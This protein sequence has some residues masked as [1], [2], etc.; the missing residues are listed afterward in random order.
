[1]SATKFGLTLS[2]E[3][4]GPQRLVELASLAEAA[5]FDFVSISDHF[6]PWIPE[7]GHSPNVWP[8]LGAIAATTEQLEIAVGVTCPIMRIHPAI[9]A[10]L[11]ATTAG[12]CDGR[13][14]WGV[15]SGEALNEH[16]LGD[17][18]PPAPQRIEMLREA[19]HLIRELWTGENVTFSGDHF[20]VENARI[21]DPSE[22]EIPLVVSAFGDRAAGVAAEVGDGLWITGT[23][24]PID[25]W[26]EAGGSGPVYSQLSFCWAEDRYEALDTVA[27]IWPNT[28]VPGQ[29]SQDLPTPEHFEM[30]TSIVT[31][32]ML[33]E[34]VVHGPD[35]DPLVENVERAVAAGVDHVYFHQI[36]SDQ[37]AFLQV[38]KDELAQRLRS[39]SGS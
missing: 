7:Q 13:F 34:Q 29:L 27:R 12:L 38:W 1:M 9:L 8:V 32:E 35:L 2:S 3:E 39:G 6:H 10:H 33:A 20:H 25:V 26:K 22:H 15:G 4:H 5:G 21:Y 19:V 36:G 18:W 31:K 14:T 37:E 24:G 28:A 16:V 30:A 11:T 23:D 17:R